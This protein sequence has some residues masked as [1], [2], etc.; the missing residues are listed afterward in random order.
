MRINVV[1][2]L[3]LCLTFLGTPRLWAQTDPVANILA[4][5]NQGCAPVEV[6]FYDDTAGD[7]DSLFWTFEGGTPATSSDSN[8]VVNYDSPGTFQVTLIAYGNGTQSQD[9]TDMD[10]RPIRPAPNFKYNNEA[11]I[12]SFENLSPFETDYQWDFGDGH[13]SS[14]A[15]PIHTYEFAGTYLVKL[16]ATNDCSAVEHVDVVVV[17]LNHQVPNYTAN[18]SVDPYT[19]YFRPGVNLGYFPPWNDITLSDIAAGRPELGIKGAGVKSIRPGLFDS[20][21]Q[22]FGWDA[23][24]ETYKHF[25][26][27]GLEDNT[28]IVGFPAPEHRD[29][30]FYCPEHQS[31]LFANL[32]EPIWDNGENG[33]PI[34]DDNDF[35][36]YMY[37]LVNLN[38]DYI[39]FWEIWNEPGFDFSHV[40]GYL[41]PGEDGNWWE[42]NPDPCDYKLRA[43]IFHY[44]RILR[45][46]YEI[47]KA[48]DPDSYVT[49]ASVGYPAFL[50]AILRN[51]DN[52][53]EGTVN[54]DF[55][56]KGGAYFDAIGIHTYPHFD[57]TLSE[58]NN[59]IQDF[60]HFRHTDLAIT[61]IPVTKTSFES[62]LES[63]GYDGVTYPE[64]EWIIT[65]I[66]VPRKQIGNYIGS[67]EAQINFLMKAFVECIRS[68][69]QEMHVY[70]M[71]ESHYFEEA[72]TEFH[73]MGFYQRLYSVFPYDQI[74]NNGAMAFKTM[75]DQLFQATYDTDRTAALNLPAGIDGGAFLN[76][77]GHYV[78]AL[79]AQTSIDQSEEASGTYSF[80]AEWNISELTMHEWDAS[81][82]DQSQVMGS[83]NIQLTGT[84]ILLTDLGNTIQLPPTPFFGF[85]IVGNCQ[86]SMVQFADASTNNTTSWFWEFEG[87]QPAT[88]TEQ[89][90]LVSFSNSGTHNVQLTVSNANGAQ[91]KMDQVEVHVIQD[92][93]L[94]GFD[95]VIFDRLISLVNNSSNATSYSWQMGDSNIFT[96]NN[97]SHEYAVGGYYTIILTAINDCDSSSTS[98][99]VIILPEQLAPRPDFTASDFGGC[100][101]AEIQF[102]DLSTA[103]TTS[104]YWLLSGAEPNFS[105]E[106]NPTVVYDQVGSFEVELIAGNNAGTMTKYRAN[107]ITIEEAPE[108]AYTVDLQGGQASFINTSSGGSKFYWDF[109]DGNL[110]NDYAPTHS[111]NSSG[112]YSVTLSVVN[113]CDSINLSQ[114]VIIEGFPVSQFNIPNTGFCQTANLVLTDESTGNIDSLLW[115]IP[116]GSPAMSDASTLEVDFANTG[117]YDISLITWNAVG[118]DTL[119]Q[120]IHIFDDALSLFS[121]ESNGN[122]F[123][124]TNES[125]DGQY[126]SWE[127][128]DGESSEEISP[129]HEYLL[130][131]EYTV[132]LIVSNPCG[133][134]TST[135]VL[136]VATSTK[137]PE[138][139]LGITIY[140][141]PTTA[142]FSVFGD[143]LSG[144]V[145]LDIKDGLGRI[146]HS[147]RLLSN[148][149]KLSHNIYPKGC[150]PGIYFVQISNGVVQVTTKLIIQ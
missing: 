87:G 40:T 122:L 49:L 97:P 7:V 90:P 79:W 129:T 96:E 142:Q 5:I 33:T 98:H 144:E 105:E 92:A 125:H 77:E 74:I 29:T 135:Q 76:L 134:D 70:D 121:Y 43:P 38:K 32:Y 31:E 3:L 12:V 118:A 23:R 64:K 65:E 88:S 141:N 133:M 53:N 46:S 9:A 149:G 61:S 56:L 14:E 54:S 8:P 63:Y 45:I 128:G 107:Y 42:N 15:N 148:G 28:L 69:I 22:Q 113:A 75:S 93:P 30:T 10:I 34:D 114:Q 62:V 18:D 126:Y 55:P 112:E 72:S 57:G 123:N 6:E 120:S 25:D 80:P 132:Q 82:S 103:N 48:V 111:Y 59:D 145:M 94:A 110:S 16:R 143:Y 13:F 102:H 115:L 140:P 41:P 147:Q 85:D 86:Q 109:G 2:L 20:F 39:K 81:Y 24:V 127:F 17:N 11:L 100:P 137:A 99:D 36:V 27:I 150:A 117:T 78:Y 89:N 95:F 146:V 104:W 66:N 26:D 4:N 51:T 1:C 35:A 44:N 130:D 91:T 58:W 47:I 139:D 136:Q 106:Q 83:Q 52:P 119:T 67:E 21:L 73:M 60:D 84:P 37:K 108:V 131:G 71:A 124:F 116:G 50:D 101:N 68:G 138:Q 19:G